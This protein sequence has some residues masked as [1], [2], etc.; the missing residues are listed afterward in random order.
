[1][2]VPPPNSRGWKVNVGRRFLECFEKRKT[3]KNNSWIFVQNMI[4]SVRNGNKITLNDCDCLSL[5]LFREAWTSRSQNNRNESFFIHRHL[6][7]FGDLDPGK[8]QPSSFH[9]QDQQIRLTTQERFLNDIAFL[10]FKTLTMRWTNSR[11][12]PIFLFCRFCVFAKVKCD[13]ALSRLLARY[14]KRD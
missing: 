6:L 13:V 7:Q 9:D 4:Y 12:F 14:P 10:N 8:W 3:I 11:F 2:I 1:M 5:S